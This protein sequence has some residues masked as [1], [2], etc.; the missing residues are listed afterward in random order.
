MTT[1]IVFAGNISRDKISCMDSIYRE[2]WGGSSLNS[3]L[4]CRVVSNK[5]IGLITAF[6][7]DFDRNLLSKNRIQ[8]ENSFVSR[9]SNAFLINER[10]DTFTLEEPPYLNYNNIPNIN[11]NILHVSFR[12]GVPIERI[13]DSKGVNFKS[14]SIDVMIHSIK[15]YLPLFQKYKDA[16]NFA[17][18]N[19]SEYRIIKDYLEPSANILVTDSGKDVTYFN[20]ETKKVFRVINV[21]SSKV[22]STTGAGDCFIG[23]FWGSFLTNDSFDNSINL[24]IKLASDSVKYCGVEDF[25]N[26]SNLLKH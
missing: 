2:V 22:V 6:G 9:K 24:G 14:L 7:N 13:L 5:G 19:S 25:I 18:C 26:N 16:I 11:T 12:R 8:I 20:G 15:D 10:K 23:G 17:F 1:D 4:V 21:D 3:S